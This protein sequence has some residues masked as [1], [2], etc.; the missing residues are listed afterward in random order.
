M[1][2]KS[3]GSEE[4]DAHLSEMEPGHIREEE[5]DAW[6]DALGERI[7]GLIDKIGSLG[8]ASHAAGVSAS[9]LRRYAR[10]QVQAPFSAMVGLARKAGVSLEWLAT[11]QGP[12]TPGKEP[13][14]TVVAIGPKGLWRDEPEQEA[15][16]PANGPPGPALMAGY[17]SHHP[18]GD[19]G[20][21]PTAKS[22]L[23][24]DLPRLAA[25]L[26]AVQQLPEA[27]DAQRQLTLAYVM[28][29]LIHFLDD[30]GHQ[31]NH[32]DRQDLADLARM[33]NKAVAAL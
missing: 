5:S 25:C 21:S 17:S 1:Q 33:L 10:G 2:G 7:D 13:V 29:D 28:I 23:P 16:R 8:L 20:H 11:G 12:R 30:Q 6:K 22:T 9:T 31:P 24:A 4:S 26:E 3:V 15:S 32:F 14:A 18:P 19:P 27:L